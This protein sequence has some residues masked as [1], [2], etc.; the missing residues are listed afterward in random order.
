MNIL[1][2]IGGVAPA[3]TVACYQQ[4]VKA[5][6]ERTKDGSYPRVIINSIDLQH[7]LG[8]LNSGDLDRLA[9]SVSEEIARLHRAGAEFA[10]IASNTPHIIFDELSRRSPIPLISIVEATAQKAKSLAVVRP[11]LFGSRFT[12]RSSIYPDVFRR[13]GMEIFVPNEAEQ[14][15][16]HERYMGELVAEVFLPETRTGFLEIADRM[17]QRHNIDALILGGTEM[18]LLLTDASH[19]GI[20]LLDTTAIHVERAVTALLNAEAF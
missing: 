19:N 9:D 1:G 7:A 12:M 15:F 8:F 11:G 6:R 13:G 17:I 4:L 2:I 5:Y 3:S 20:P 14:E 18:P 16:I 10:I